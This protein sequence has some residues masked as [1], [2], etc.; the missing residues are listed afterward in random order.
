MKNIVPLIVALLLGVFAIVG[1]KN[2]MSKKDQEVIDKTAPK[3]V[4]VAKKDI[5][6]GTR[7]TK[8]MLAQ[9]SLPGQMLPPNVITPQNVND[10]DGQAVNRDMYEGEAFLWSYLGAQTQRKKLSEVITLDERATTISVDNVS[11]VDGYIHPNDRVDVYLSVQ[12]PTKKEQKV[13]SQQGDLVTIE[14]DDT[15]DV[16]FMLLQNV[17]VIATGPS[18]GKGHV[19]TQQDYGTVTLSLTPTEAGLLKFAGE[20]GKI[21]LT[22]RNPQDFGEVSKVDI[23]DI[24]SILDVAKLREVQNERKKRIEVYRKGKG[25]LIER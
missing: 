16:V 25:V 13:P 4:I 8:A 15:K 17:S 11:G 9:R 3:I 19:E 24:N 10:I 7:L 21:S 22:L 6:A 14:V 20:T 23:F 5:P 1:V 2:Y 12:V 18:F